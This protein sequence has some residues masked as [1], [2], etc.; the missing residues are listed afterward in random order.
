MTL[1]N[2]AN[3]KSFAGIW[4]ELKWR[5]LISQSTDE[6]ELSKKLNSILGYFLH[7]L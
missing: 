5:G 6:A 1:S 2:Q 3:D 7:R 4:E